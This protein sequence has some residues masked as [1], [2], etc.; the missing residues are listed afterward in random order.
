MSKV[1]NKEQLRDA[2]FT[3]KEK[4]RFESTSFV[5]CSFDDL[6][7]L[8]FLDCEFRNCDLSNLNTRNTRLQNVSFFDCKL[9]GLNFSGAIDFALE[10]HFENCLMNY[11]T[12]DSKKL[13]RSS[14]K[15]CRLHQVNFTQADLS[16]SSMERCDLMEAQFMD[17]NLSTLDF[18]SNVNFLIDPEQNTLKKTKFLT[19]QLQYLL[20]RHDIII[21]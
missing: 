1:K 12:F 21:E 18:T 13:N 7:N 5:H 8:N 10:L 4:E 6:S 20:Y 3:G 14:F 2:H 9:L 15:N 11:A 16:K 17:T 19:E